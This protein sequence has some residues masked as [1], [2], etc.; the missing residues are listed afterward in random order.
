MYEDLDENHPAGPVVAILFV[1]VVIGT[2]AC[3]VLL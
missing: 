3:L 2:V 1:I